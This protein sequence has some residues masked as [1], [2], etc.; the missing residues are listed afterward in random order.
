MIDILTKK[1]GGKNFFSKNIK[2]VETF[3]EK[4]YGGE[5]FFSKKKLG[6]KIWKSKI[7]FSKKNIFKDQKVIYVWSS[8]SND[9]WRLSTKKEGDDFFQEKLV[10]EDIFRAKKVGEDLFQAKLSQ[11]GLWYIIWPFLEK[12][13][14][15]EPASRAKNSRWL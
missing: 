15:D 1:I 7:S 2:W 6:Y 12:F 10:S 9:H 13:I 11:N 8:D 3:F 14:F 5:D 4:N